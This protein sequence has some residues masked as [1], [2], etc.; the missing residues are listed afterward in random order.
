MVILA[1]SRANTLRGL[2][3]RGSRKRGL[4]Y[5]P[6]T[7]DDPKPSTYDYMPQSSVDHAAGVLGVY[8]RYPITYAFQG[9]VR[10]SVEADT[11]LS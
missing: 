7:S 4:Q 3:R 9:K 1:V 6:L 8:V 11:A 5:A 10:H 2:S